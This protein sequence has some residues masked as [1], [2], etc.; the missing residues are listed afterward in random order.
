MSR[1]HVS[2]PVRAHATGVG[3]NL[4]HGPGAAGRTYTMTTAHIYRTD[5]DRLAEHWGV[6]DELE[7]RIQLGTIASPDPAAFAPALHVEGEAAS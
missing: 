2:G 7:A 5:G 3:V 1:N 6:R 4:V